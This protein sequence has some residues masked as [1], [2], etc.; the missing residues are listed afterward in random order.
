MDCV[1]DKE[2]IGWSH[3]DGSAQ[4]LNVYMET[5]DKRCPSAVLT[6]TSNV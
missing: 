2:L 4:W 6:G 1:V 5:S 3:P